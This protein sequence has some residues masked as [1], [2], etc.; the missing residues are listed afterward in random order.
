M[1]ELIGG[2]EGCRMLDWWAFVGCVG[3]DRV[4]ALRASCDREAW[5]AFW[6]RLC[7]PPWEWSLTEFVTRGSLS[8]VVV[9]VELVGW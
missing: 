6:E 4:V 8:Q 9:V 5:C 7:C 1:A 2:G 3:S